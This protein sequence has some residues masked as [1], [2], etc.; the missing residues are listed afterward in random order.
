MGKMMRALREKETKRKTTGRKGPT[1]EKGV[2]K[3]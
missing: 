3:N 1:K 2:S